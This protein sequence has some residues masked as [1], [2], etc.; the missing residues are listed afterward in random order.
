MLEETLR[1][2]DMGGEYGQRVNLGENIELDP[3]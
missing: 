3:T 2:F 1:T